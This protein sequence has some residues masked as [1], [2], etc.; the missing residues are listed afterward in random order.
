VN[1][2]ISLKELDSTKSH[3]LKTGKCKLPIWK[4]CISIVKEIIYKIPV[5]GLLEF[6][7]DEF[8]CLGSSIMRKNGNDS[9]ESMQLG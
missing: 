4:S 9:P 7:T 6:S 3:F 1:V 8:E 2:V 5:L